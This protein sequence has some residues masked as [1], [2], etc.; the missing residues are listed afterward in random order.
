M[1]NAPLAPNSAPPE[2]WKPTRKWY[3]L[4][5]TGV[6]TIL[7]SFIDSGNFD[8]TERGMS[9]TLLVGAAAAYFKKNP[10]T[11]GGAE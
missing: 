9:A 8:A 5:V 10:A 4:V 6:A 11:P 2:N 1:P 7:A 3:A